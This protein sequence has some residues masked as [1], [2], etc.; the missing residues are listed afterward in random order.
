MSQIIS[1][2]FSKGWVGSIIG[3]IGISIALILYFKSKQKP[4]LV[5]QHR[6]LKLLGHTAGLLPNDIEVHH[7]G[8]KIPKLTKTVL[9]IWNG[10]EKTIKGTDIVDRDCLRVELPEDSQLLSVNTINNS[11]SVINFSATRSNEFENSI[12]LSF[13]F[14]DQNDGSVVEILHTSS[15]P[16]LSIIGTIMGLPNGIKN[17]GKITSG[18]KIFSLAPFKV[19][20]PSRLFYILTST[21]GLF[22][23][24]I[25]LFVSSKSRS[26]DNYAFVIMG[27]VYLAMGLFGLWIGRRKYPKSLHCD[28]LD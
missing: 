22:L 7:K 9:I 6:G 24:I 11:R 4:I 27:L 18:R 20:L 15:D 10:G 25:S 19:V 23:T 2:V 8:I 5:F 13:D 12:K 3:I 16:Y 1:D 14:L 17:F 28:A 26:T 21:A